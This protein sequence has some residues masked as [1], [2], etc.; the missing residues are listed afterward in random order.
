MFQ[1]YCNYH[2]VSP[3]TREI[4]ISALANAHLNFNLDETQMQAVE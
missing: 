2:A 3:R 1:S 4:L